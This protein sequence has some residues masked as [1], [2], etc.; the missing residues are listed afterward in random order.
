MRIPTERKHTT[1]SVSD[2]L[3]KRYSHLAP[4]QAAEQGQR[5]SDSSYRSD[6]QR[7]DSNIE[8]A[9]GRPTKEHFNNSELT[10]AETWETIEHLV[11]NKRFVAKFRN[12]Y[13]RGYGRHLIELSKIAETKEKPAH[14]FNSVTKVQY[15]EGEKTGRL[16]DRCLEYLRSMLQVARQAETIVRSF[17]VESQLLALKTV[18]RLRKKV[19]VDALISHVRNRGRDKLRFFWYLYAEAKEGRFYDMPDLS[20]QATS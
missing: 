15:D 2:E 8:A 10:W 16:S 18:W 4:S 1:S 3:S 19:N 9:H 6:S 11:S 17:G 14:W 13:T 5:T 20:H 12:L 7:S